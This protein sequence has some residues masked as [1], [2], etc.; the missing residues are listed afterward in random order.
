MSNLDLWYLN[1][2][3]GI[4]TMVLLS[5]VVALG[6][7]TRRSV[8]LPGLPRFVTAGLHRNAA[9]IAVGLLAVHIGTAVADPYALLR[10]VDVVVPFGGGY[11]P[12]WVGLG[13]LTLDLLA[14]LVVTSLVRHRLSDRTWRAVHLS[15]YAFW[16]LALA[17]GLGSGTDAGRTWSL[18]TTAVCVL[19]VVGAAVWRLT[20]PGFRSPQ[21]A[22]R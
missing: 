3:T 16:P 5:L 17:H 1:R 14:V 12:F 8:P 22:V 19:A 4:V 9:L 13:T 18:A 10:L 11:R 15:A 21:L 6:V 7:L 20:S 2:A